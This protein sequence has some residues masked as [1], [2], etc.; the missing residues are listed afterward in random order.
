MT[1]AG[2]SCLF[3]SC[4]AGVREISEVIE[5]SAFVTVRRSV[6]FAFIEVVYFDKLC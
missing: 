5:A 1:V 4:C 3:K 2:I 6:V